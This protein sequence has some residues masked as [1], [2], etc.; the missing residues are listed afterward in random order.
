MK[1]KYG[2]MGKMLFV[3]LSKGK[4]HEKEL[5]QDAAKLFI[6]GMGIGGKI[7]YEHMKPKTDPLGPD[8]II[9][10]GTGPLTLSGTYCA[11]RF[12]VMG[13]SPLT[14]FWGTASGGGTFANAL[15]ASG[16]D[17]VFFT[18][19]AKEPVYLLVQDEKAEI[20]SAKDVWGKDTVE[21]EKIIRENEKNDKLKMVCIGPAGEKLSRIAAVINDGGRAAARSGLGAVMGSKNLKAI[22]CD[23]DKK[24]EVFDEEKVRKLMR[25]GYEKVRNNPT[26][27]FKELSEGGTCSAVVSHLATHDTPI[28][29]WAGTNVKDFPEEKWEKVG[30]P[31]LKKYIIG[32]YF[33]PG[34]PVGCGGWVRVPGGK[35]ALEKAHKPEYE[36]LAAFGPMCLNDNVESILYANDLCNRYGLDTISAGATIAFAME[37]YEK[38]ILTKKDTGGIDLRWGD[39]DALIELLKKMCLR[40]GIGD[41]LADGAKWAAG[42]IG[43]GA[44]RFSMDVCGEMVPM[45]DPRFDVGWGL[46][47]VLDPEAAKHTRGQLT[48]FQL[49]V[50]PI[51]AGVLDAPKVIDRHDTSE[52][53]VQLSTASSAWAKSVFSAGLCLLGSDALGHPLH[54]VL[55]AV[56][57]WNLSPKD[58]ITTGI[59]INTL[60]HAFNLREGW[61]PSHY[62]L[63][64]RIAGNPPLPEGALKG[65]TIDF[66]KLKK[67]YYKAMGWNPETGEIP[68]EKLKE[69]G[70]ENIVKM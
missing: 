52:R 49:N 54:E 11:S 6:G 33:C 38:G 12:T 66:E 14:G 26:P 31:T 50:N 69:L 44:E 30:L 41:L 3:D 45:H 64:P 27:M 47:Y 70:L 63:P 8:S 40:E 53:R 24:P 68:N 18:G 61:K 35:Y 37:C 5:S 34:C 55:N 58:L 15:K 36:T 10:F 60:F 25:S 2:Y 42:K 22:A 19:I 1:P 9:G 20:K 7:I 17:M 28:K 62:T 4:I 51:L 23:G 59:R 16:Y 21:T 43:R 65:I 56:T 39:S 13:K 29:N 46:N 67:Y 48:A 57:G 32:K